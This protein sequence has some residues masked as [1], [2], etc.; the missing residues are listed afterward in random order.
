MALGALCVI[1]NPLEAP[2][3]TLLYLYLP[4][5]WGMADDDSIRSPLLMGPHMDTKG[6]TGLKDYKRKA[7]SLTWRSL[8]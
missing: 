2:S 6:K 3:S 1:N 4:P 8:Q 5:I 7:D